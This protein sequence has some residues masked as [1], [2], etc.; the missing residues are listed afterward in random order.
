[1]RRKKKVTKEDQLK[2]AK[3][4]AKDGKLYTEPKIEQIIELEAKTVANCQTKGAM[5]FDVC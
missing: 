4:V 3:L 2:K 5:S 1:M